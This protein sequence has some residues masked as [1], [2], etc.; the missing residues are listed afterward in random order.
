MLFRKKSSDSAPEVPSPSKPAEMRG[1]VLWR[2]R[3]TEQAIT[4]S[5]PGGDRQ[6]ALDY[7]G[8]HVPHVTYG[9]DPHD[10]IEVIA[11]KNNE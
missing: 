5:F 4:S 2:V 8:R 7:L 6:D 1:K 10:V 3:G 11:V 9:T